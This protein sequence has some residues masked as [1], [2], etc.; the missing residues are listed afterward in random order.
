[1]K[2]IYLCLILI[3]VT[4]SVKGHKQLFDVLEKETSENDSL[5]SN[6]NNSN[7]ESN[8]DNSELPSLFIQ[9]SEE[10]ENGKSKNEAKE[11]VKSLFESKE[12]SETKT[13]TTEANNSSKAQESKSLFENTENNNTGAK[14]KNEETNKSNSNSNSNSSSQVKA[15]EQNNNNSENNNKSKTEENNNKKEKSANKNAISTKTHKKT[16]ANNKTSQK[17]NKTTKASNNNTRKSKSTKKSEKTNKKGQRKGRLCRVEDDG[18]GRKLRMCGKGSITR[19]RNKAEKPKGKGKAGKKRSEDLSFLESKI[20]SLKSQIKGLVEANNQL[21]D[22]VKL[23]ESSDKN[24][25][26]KASNMLSFIQKET[27]NITNLKKNYGKES[28][29]IKKQIKDKDD[30]YNKVL[31]KNNYSINFLGNQIAGLEGEIEHL[32][33]EITSLSKNKQVNSAEAKNINAN[34]VN[35][36]N[37]S[38]KTAKFGEVEISGKSISLNAG[39]VINFGNKT[40]TAKDI[41]NNVAFV[42]MVK[43]YCGEDFSKCKILTKHEYDDERKDEEEILKNVKKLRKDSIKA[44]NN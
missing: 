27:S 11:T 12:Q 7:V 6:T 15:G 8:N 4:T 14:S 18:T 13:K 20:S 22:K 2:F 5:N 19:N 31:D 33:K 25:S 26:K 40:F 43:K 21:V 29:A 34:N 24:K 17:N 36:A 39:T 28:T 44:F 10:V 35:A 38:G 16:K 32:K 30:I 3:L 23:I 42:Q 1:M 37:I 9:K 41:V